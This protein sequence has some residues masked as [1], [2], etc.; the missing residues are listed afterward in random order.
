[1]KT[2]KKLFALVLIIFMSIFVSFGAKYKPTTEEY[3][4]II[5]HLN[6]NTLISYPEKTLSKNNPNSILYDETKIT[7][8]EFTKILQELYSNNYVLI[9]LSELYFIDNNTIYPKT[10]FLPQNKKPIILS[11]NNVTY[12]T[13]YQNSG[14]IDKIIIDNDNKFATYSIK[15]NIQNRIS[16]DNEFLPILENFIRNNPDFSFN[17]AR[18]IIFLTISNGVLGYKIDTKNSSSKHDIKRVSEILKRLEN[19]GWEFGSNNY[20]ISSDN[21]LNT[22]EFINNISLW[23]KHINPIIDYTPHYAS[24]NGDNI[25]NNPEKFDILLD[26]QF[27]SF[28]YNSPTPAITIK[29]NSIQMSRKQVNGKSLRNTPEIFNDIFDSKK[30]YDHNARIIPYPHY[31]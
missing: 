5:E 25:T 22:I 26:N 16:Y 30:V 19:K 28:F 4:G 24:I 8:S 10:L 1:M 23:K 9:S 2:L 29:N 15:Q 17:N 31:Q 14:D 27:V 21:S 20:D 7:P 3:N 18:G 11:F 13:S 6:F 12:K